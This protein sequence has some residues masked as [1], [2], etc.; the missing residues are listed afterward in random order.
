M[1]RLKQ[2]EAVT[3]HLERSLQLPDGALSALPRMELAGNRRLLIEGCIG[4]DEYDEDRICLR[5][6][7]GV[8][9]LIG[10]EL[11]MHRLHPTCAVVTGRLLSIEFLG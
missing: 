9:R 7:N 5:T 11:C 2:K 1:K 10:Q 3:R 6:T 8:I 4:I